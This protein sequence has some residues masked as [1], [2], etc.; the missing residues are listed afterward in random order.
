M[1]GDVTMSADPGEREQT[2]RIW[3]A[4][5]VSRGIDEQRA[6]KHFDEW[7]SEDTYFPIDDELDA[8]RQAGFDAQCVWR[9]PPNTLL[10]GRKQ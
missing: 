9:E 8:M 4:H 10:V 6:H 2:Y 7:S 1:N 5:L 3:A